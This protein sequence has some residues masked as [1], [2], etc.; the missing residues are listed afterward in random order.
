M[1]IDFIQD[2]RNQQIEQL[3]RD[4]TAN[5]RRSIR[6]AFFLLARDLKDTANRE[7]LK[8]QKTGRVYTYRTRSGARRR[9]QA[10]APGE[11]HANLTG[12]LRKS[13]GWQVNGWESLTF[14]Y[15]VDPRGPAPDYANWVENGSSRMEAR[16]SLQNAMKAVERNAESY[17]TETWYDVMDFER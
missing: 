10:S 1:S 3:L 12:A 4:T 9:H 7:I 6:Q 15:G 16:P 11:T 17:F 8:G 5:T 2:R 13:I 14:G